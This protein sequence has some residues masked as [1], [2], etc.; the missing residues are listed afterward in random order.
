MY[1]SE[2]IKDNSNIFLVFLYPSFSS[3]IVQKRLMMDYL[4]KH[5]GGGFQSKSKA[6]RPGSCSGLTR[7]FSHSLKNVEQTIEMKEEKIN[8]YE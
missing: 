8:V 3:V 5:S 7:S 1:N 4:I 6:T 2:W